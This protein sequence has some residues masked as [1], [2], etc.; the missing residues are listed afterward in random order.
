MYKPHKEQFHKFE[1]TSSGVFGLFDTPA[2]I[3]SAA[4][5]TKE[6]IIRTLIVL[7][8]IQFTDWTTRWGFLVPDFLG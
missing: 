2:E 7:L 4:A 6:K 3:I 8:R 1:E 5:K